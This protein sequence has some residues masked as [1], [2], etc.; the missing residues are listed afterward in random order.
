MLA[1]LTNLKSDRFGL[2]TIFQ[3]IIGVII[4]FGGKIL[5]LTIYNLLFSSAKIAPS[6][7]PTGIDST[8]PPLMF[9]VM[10]VLQIVIPF[11]L[12]CLY[13]VKILKVPL[14]DFRICKPKNIGIWILCAFALP[15]AVTAF[16]LLLVPGTF[17]TNELNTQ[18][19]IFYI[20]YAVFGTC[21][22]AGISEELLFRG[23]IMRI[24][25]VRWNKYIAIIVPSVLFG[26]IHITN[27]QNPTLIDFILLLV[28]GT[29]VGVMFSMIAYQSGSIWASAI[30]HGLFN[31]IMGGGILI[32]DLEPGPSIFTY[33]LK[34]NSVLLTG[35]EVGIETALP[36]IVGYGMV[37][38]IAWILLRKT[39]G[40]T[41]RSPSK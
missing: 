20:V 22:V 35:A 16:Y 29:S 25:E 24:L 36:A 37:I 21:L 34:P 32:I 3:I 8:F 26:A 10:I 27:L 13:I 40:E 33:T 39:T 4:Y 14:R 7:S 1:I 41:I 2:K 9:V 11:L 5:S 12:I 28:A 19:L 31:L 23:F 15:L 6:M 38:C 30:V 18:Q 17:A